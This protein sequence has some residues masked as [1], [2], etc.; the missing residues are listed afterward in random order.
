M[1]RGGGRSDAPGARRRFD[2]SD[3]M[4]VYSVYRRHLHDALPGATPRDPAPRTAAVVIHA[5]ILNLMAELRADTRTFWR[6]VA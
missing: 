4:S 1:G 6:S 5:R 3:V 2:F